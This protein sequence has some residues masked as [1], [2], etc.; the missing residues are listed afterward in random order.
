MFIVALIF[1]GMW[2]YRSARLYLVSPQA[3]GHL[4]VYMATLEILPMAV[5]YVGSAKLIAII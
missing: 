5:L 1:I 4:L 3:A 2:M